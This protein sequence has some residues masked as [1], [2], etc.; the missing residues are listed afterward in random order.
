MKTTDPHTGSDAALHVI[1]GR[2]G[3]WSVR[4]EAGLNAL[5]V[6]ASTTDA[7]RAACRLARAR[8]SRRVVVH[9]RYCRLHTVG[10][11]TGSGG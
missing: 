3:S 6:H 4:T 9:D 2:K 10:V 5:S 8:G 1:P 11:D 7:E